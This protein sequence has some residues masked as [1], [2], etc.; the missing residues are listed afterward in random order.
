MP[1]PPI[2]KSCRREQHLVLGVL[3]VEEIERF[4]MECV[5]VP[6]PIDYPPNR[7][8]FDRWLRRWQRLFT[9]ESEDQDGQ[10]KTLP[11]PPEQLEQFAPVV[12]TTLRRVWEEQDARQRHWYFYRLRDAHQQMI[13]E[14]ENPGFFEIKS[15]PVQRLTDQ[16][17]QAAPRL[18]PFEAAIYWLQ[19]QAT[20]LRCPGRMCAAPYF[21][22]TKKGQKFCSPECADPSR[23]AAKRLWWAENRGK[24]A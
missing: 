20:L 10:W 22:R 16:T 9:F 18:S 21:F 6:N 23:R 13:L 4:L 12:R 24:S 19:N 1:K 14:I 5:N 8:A 2:K 17:L 7:A 15:N 3:S 11:I